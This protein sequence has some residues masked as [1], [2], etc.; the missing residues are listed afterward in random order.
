MQTGRVPAS[1]APF[2]SAAAA[3]WA[4]GRMWFY[5]QEIC[6]PWRLTVVDCELLEA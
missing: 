5:K 6:N 1:P 3:R 4:A 2:S